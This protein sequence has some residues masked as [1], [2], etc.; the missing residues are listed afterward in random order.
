MFRSFHDSN[1]AHTADHTQNG[2]ILNDFDI[3]IR[4]LSARPMKPMQNLRQALADSHVAA[5]SILVLLLS[6]IDGAFRAL[7]DPSVRAVDFLFHAVVVMGWPVG[8]Y[9]ADVLVRD[10]MFIFVAFYSFAAVAGGGG[11]WI[12]AR[13]VYGVGP[14]QALNQCGRSLIRG[15]NA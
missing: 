14:F 6:A 9:R 15:Q 3:K 5:V 13:W 8:Q 10:S 1:L 2:S 4:A 7:W 12:L 11:A